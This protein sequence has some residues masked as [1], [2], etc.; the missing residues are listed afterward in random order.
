MEII[1]VIKMDSKQEQLKVISFP[2]SP[3]NLNKL[4]N[5]KNVTYSHNSTTNY[6]N[7]PAQVSSSPIGESFMINLKQRMHIYSGIQK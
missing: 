2:K 1:I 7:E 4:S 5:S 6:E 3:T